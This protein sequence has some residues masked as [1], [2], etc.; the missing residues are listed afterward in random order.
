MKSL[1]LVSLAMVGLFGA[2]GAAA[3]APTVAQLNR[4]AKVLTADGKNAGFVSSVNHGRDGVPTDV[5]LI[6]D[7][8]IVHVL[9]ATITIGEKNACNTSLK[10]A[11]IVK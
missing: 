3:D 10:Y 4:C 11:D 6:H 8:S 9:P 1:T 2:T 5:E 7:Q